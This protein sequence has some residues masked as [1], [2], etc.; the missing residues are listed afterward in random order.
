MGIAYRVVESARLNV[1]V[2]D[3][4]VTGEDFHSFAHEQANDPAW[5][6][7]TRSLTDARTAIIPAVTTETVNG[8]AALYAS[9]RDQDEPYESAIIGGN[10]FEVAGNYAEF[11]SDGHTHTIAF[12]DVVTACIWLRVD[13]DLV[14]ATIDELR[15][16]LRHSSAP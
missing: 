10:A 4:P 3:G 13:S 6:A 11:R 16:K 15:E 12:N 2:I 8:F 14:R 7:T 1:T 9:M 5:H